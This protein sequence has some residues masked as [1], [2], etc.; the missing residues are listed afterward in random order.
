[1]K[2]TELLKIGKRVKEQ[3]EMTFQVTDHKEF[4]HMVKIVNNDTGTLV[5]RTHE[6]KEGQIWLIYSVDGHSL[7]GRCLK[8]SSFKPL[9]SHNVEILIENWKRLPKI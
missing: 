9:E 2:T 5:Y 1:M 7:S 3:L 8:L 4:V 6:D